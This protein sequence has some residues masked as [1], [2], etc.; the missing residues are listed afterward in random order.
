[1][2]RREALKL[3]AAAAFVPGTASG[4][5]LQGDFYGWYPNQASLLD[6]IRRNRNAF[7]SNQNEAIKGTG[8]GKVVYL[9]K[10]LETVMGRT[11]APHHQQAPDCVAQAYA[12]GSDIL[13]AVQI[14]SGRPEKWV[15]KAAT[16]PIYGGSRVNVG[17]YRGPGGGSTGHWA[18]EWVSR[19]GVLLRQQ[20]PG[21][22]FTT[23]DPILTEKYG[24]HGCPAELVPFARLHPIKT[25]AICKSY[26]ELRDC[27]ENGFPIIV[28]SN[29]GF[30]SGH[31]VRDRDGFLRRSR[32]P[33]YHAML[34]A[35]FDDVYRRKGALCLNSWGSNWISGPTRGEQP[36]GSFWIDVPTVDAMLSQ[37]DSFAISSFVGY[38]RFIIPPYILR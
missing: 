28:C 11:F 30:G 32:R 21:H 7:I 34:F 1:M 20:Y 35:G 29:A 27:I 16:E 18:A 19:Y 36:A 26:S 8:E 17:N 2:D 6:F 12:L 33:W 25:V 10:A 23:Y 9:H 3:L 13:K 31:C 15:T 38:P 37:G 5:D 14:V 24:R 22:D 4:Q